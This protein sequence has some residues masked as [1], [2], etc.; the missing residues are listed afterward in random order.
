M[1]KKFDIVILGGGP[2]GYVAAI[3]AAQLEKKV[4]LIEDDRV[5]GTCINYGCIPTKYLLYHSHLLSEV[6]ESKV[7]DGPVE[8]LSIN[9]RNMQ[10]EKQGVVDKLVSGLE[11]ILK[12]NG[13]EV[14]KGK[15]SL[16]DERKVIV[17][18]GEEET[19][20]EGE[21]IIL[22]TGSK[23]A[24]IPFLTPNGKEII[25][26]RE[27]LELGSIPKKLLIVGAG[28]IGIEMGT[29]FQRLGSDVTILEIMPTLLPG[30][31]KEIVSRL[32]RLL[33]VQGLKIF[34]QMKIEES[35]V[36]G[37]I[38]T[39]KG[40]CSKDNVPFEFEGEKVLI[41]AGRKAN[42]ENIIPPSLDLEFDELGYIR[43]N[44]KLETN[45]PGIYAIGDLSGGQLLAHKASHE[46]IVAVEN[47]SGNNR[48]MNYKILPSAVFT[49]PE[50]SSVGFTEEKAREEGID[51]KI[52]RFPLRASGRA[53][54]MKKEEGLVK[55][56]A[57]DKDEIIGAHILSPNASEIIGEI[58]LAISK[59][60]KLQDI[61]ETIHIHP[62]LSEAVMEA[63]LKARNLAIHILN[64]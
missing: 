55:L 11:F 30:W 56:L 38:V 36:D 50:F 52:G 45:I 23:P 41:S 26:S 25:T 17:R 40:M 5:G 59:R 8:K 53:L 54:T 58:T 60:L 1:Q 10:D 29:L 22:A 61:G 57:N 15:G 18:T 39:L 31:D 7:I 64:I 49:E 4:V 21:K 13:V 28:V 27:I 32:G 62:T 63:S 24:E 46:G 34:T 42:S 19:V 37:G 3:R 6:R 2:G 9:L 14:V 44:P 16:S 12:K 43:V 48:I 35:V 33:K 20:F 47:A 51:I